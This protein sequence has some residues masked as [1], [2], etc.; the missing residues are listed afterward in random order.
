MEKLTNAT[1]YD[2]TFHA[3]FFLTFP[4]FCS[5]LEFI[6]ALSLRYEKAYLICN[7]KSIV[8]CGITTRNE[9]VVV[10]VRIMNVLKFWIKESKTIEKDLKDK[11]VLEK[12]KMF[13]TRMHSTLNDNLSLKQHAELLLVR[14]ILKKF[15]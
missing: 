13:L 11:V 2:R 6:M 12:M 4:C 3:T 15:N 5:S 7:G 1:T 14:R 10:I 8:G 9:A